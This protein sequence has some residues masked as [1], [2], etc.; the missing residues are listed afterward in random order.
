M[1]PGPLPVV[2]NEPGP[3]NDEDCIICGESLSFSFRLPGEKPHIVPECGHAL[4][5]A[6]FTAVYG[7]VNQSRS[8][9]LPRKNLGVC[10][11][12]RKPIR[13][14]DGDGAKSNKLAALTGMGDKNA[15]SMFPGREQSGGPSRHTPTPRSAPT[16][17]PHDPT[18]DDPI[19]PP[20]NASVRSGGSGSGNSD[21]V[22]APSISVRSEFPSIVRTHEPTQSITCLITVELPSRRGSAPVP[23]P[24]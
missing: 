10:G 23:G 11:V 22:V 16:P 13:V 5:E 1:T 2:R 8:G 14:G 7:Q 19:E 24:L 20:T 21:Y 15:T 4:H 6:C 3:D 17:A 18:E 12:C 9:A